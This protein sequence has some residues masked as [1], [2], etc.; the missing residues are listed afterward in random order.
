MREKKISVKNKW[1]SD[2][3]M[4]LKWHKKVIDIGLYAK[5]RWYSK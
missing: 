5:Q 2:L 3:S 4:F 1:V